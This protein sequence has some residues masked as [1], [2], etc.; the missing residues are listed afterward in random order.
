MSEKRIIY[1]IN[2][3]TG[4]GAERSIIE[5]AVEM[6]KKGWNP[7][8]IT[9]LK[10]GEYI[11]KVRSEKLDFLCLDIRSHLFFINLFSLVKLLFTKKFDLIVS[12]LFWS[13][14]FSRFMGKLL[15]IPV[16]NGM[17]NI[18]LWRKKFHILLD[19]YTFPMADVYVSNSE[20]GR[21]RLMSIEKLKSSKIK[22]IKNGI[23]KSRFFEKNKEFKDNTKAKARD[24]FF[25]EYK[26]IDGSLISSTAFIIGYSARLTD[27]KN[28]FV[29]VESFKIMKN[30][31]P[32]SI[33]I[34]AGKGPLR[35]KIIKKCR[36]FGIE[37]SVV[38]AGFI[39][40]ISLF[41]NCLDLF[42]LTSFWEG[43]P[44]T[45]L[46]AMY[47]GVPVVACDSGGTAEIVKHGETGYI[48]DSYEP[49]KIAE[50]WIEMADNRALLKFF[51]MSS[52]LRVKRYFTLKGMIDKYEKIFEKLC[53]LC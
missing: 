17:R 51:S 40:D 31:H 39:D 24:K 50:K 21:L 43:L 42:V 47:F 41:Y 10:G 14:I 28:P 46:E 34:F 1:I 3:F 32:N 7:F 2:D 22:V 37:N 12:F 19:R 53:C 33:F 29:A 27:V 11:E 35:E 25:S 20:A 48:L 36:D 30:T 16:L 38:M 6:R 26:A 44:N 15:G 9:L 23:C 8:F 13:N 18:D 52:S 5:L 45:V 4:G 49:I